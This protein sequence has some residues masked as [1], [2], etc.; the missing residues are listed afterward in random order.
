MF[1]MPRPGHEYSPADSRQYFA[2]GRREGDM[3]KAWWN[4]NQQSRRWSAVAL[5]TG[6]VLFGSMVGWHAPAIAGSDNS[7]DTYAGDY[8]G[9]SLP[10]GTFIFLQYA[11]F[12]H[13]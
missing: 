12:S 3:Q 5:T 7:S 2:I 6:A 4:P 8:Q 10:I 11:G 9:G 13:G 1:V